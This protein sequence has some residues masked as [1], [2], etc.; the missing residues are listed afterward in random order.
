MGRRCTRRSFQTR[1]MGEML[2]DLPGANKKGV[3]G[4]EEALW[5]LTT[6]REFTAGISFEWRRKAQGDF[7]PKS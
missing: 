1:V 7:Q 6:R 3:N 4:D 5:E 2:G